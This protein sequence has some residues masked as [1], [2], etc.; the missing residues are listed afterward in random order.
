MLVNNVLAFKLL[1]HFMLIIGSD[2]CNQ[3]LSGHCLLILLSHDLLLSEE[4][5]VLG[6]HS[7]LDIT[8]CE[9]LRIEIIFYTKLVVHTLIKLGRC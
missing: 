5:H 8:L 7:F 6:V 1:E 3:V 2:W 9:L 4:L